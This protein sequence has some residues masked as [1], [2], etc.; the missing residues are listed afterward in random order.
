MTDVE[1]DARRS[2]FLVKNLQQFH[3]FSNFP[4]ILISQQV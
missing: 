4:C 3:T 1:N 2:R